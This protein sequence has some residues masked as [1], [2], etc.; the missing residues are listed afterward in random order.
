MET[1]DGLFLFT[2]KKTRRSRRALKKWGGHDVAKVSREELGSLSRIGGVAV[3]QAAG[4]RP[5]RPVR[6]RSVHVTFILPS[7]W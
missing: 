3:G 6:P 7:V 5:A 2:C 4:V 1:N